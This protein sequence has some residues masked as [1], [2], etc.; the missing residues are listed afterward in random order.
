MGEKNVKRV[1]YADIARISA[2]F[3]VVLL[4]TSGIRL[5]SCNPES[6][7]FV[8]AAFFDCISR[9]SVPLFIMLSGMLFLRDG[10]KLDI[11]RLYRKNI[12]RLV[13]AFV[14]WSYLYN[15]YQ[16]MIE[17]DSLGQAIVR[18]FIRMPQ[19]AMHLWFIFII[20][21]L[22]IITPFLKR[23]TER[24][25]KRETEYFLILNILLTFLPKTLSFFEAAK[26]LIEY[27]DKFE[28]TFAAGYVGLFVAGH[29]ID[30]FEHRKP[31]RLAA[32][33]LAAAGFMY[34]FLMTVF[35]SEESIELIDEFMSFKSLSAYLMAFGMLLMFKSVFGEREFKRRTASNLSAYS[36]YMF[37]VYLVHEIIITLMNAGGFV[38]LPKMPFIGI[39]VQAA[40]V[41][42]ISIVISAVIDFMPFGK[43]IV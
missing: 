28:I 37:G 36:K 17:T 26:P 40:V 1:T 14:F 27:T 43:Y 13:T 5:V 34:M 11:K 19:G 4:H 24:M 31:F 7:E 3:A 2:A 8:W 33:A 16:A 25:T 42:I 32:Y 18:A 23:M 39:P 6:A 22:Y 38:I 41:F 29:Y 20:I 35:M 15:L 9:W 30:K 12:F 21:G 10:K